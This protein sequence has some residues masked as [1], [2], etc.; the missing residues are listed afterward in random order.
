MESTILKIFWTLIAWEVEQ[1][2]RG[3]FIAFANLL[4]C[5]AVSSCSSGE[6]VENVSYLVPTKNGI[7][8][9]PVAQHDLPSWV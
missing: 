5:R 9:Y 3:A 1:K 4:A 7:A 8:V 6:N 2:M